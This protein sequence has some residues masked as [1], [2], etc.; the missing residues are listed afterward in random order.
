MYVI[1]TRSNLRNHN[2]NKTKVIFARTFI[3]GTNK[4]C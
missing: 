1:K 3:R 4:Y 2:F